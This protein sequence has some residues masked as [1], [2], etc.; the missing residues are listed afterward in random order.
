MLQKK[1]VEKPLWDILKNLQKDKTFEK[2]FLVGGTA[3]SLQNDISPIK[4]SLVY[5]DDITESNWLSVKLLHDDLSIESI[6]QHII[7]EMNEYNVI[8]E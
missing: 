7:E 8:L 3:L 1:S 2:Y 5:F 4:R 6:K